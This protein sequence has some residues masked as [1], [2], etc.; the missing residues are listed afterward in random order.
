M[1]AEH[2]YYRS[3]WGGAQEEPGEPQE[4]RTS[5]CFFFFLFCCFFIFS[6]SG[7]FFYATLPATT[8]PQ[9]AHDSRPLPGFLSS[10]SCP[11]CFQWENNQNGAKRGR[12][13]T[14]LPHF[15]NHDVDEQQTAFQ[16]APHPAWAQIHAPALQL[17]GHPQGLPAHP[18]GES[19]AANTG[20]DWFK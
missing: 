2:L 1:Q 14:T 17:R 5:L 11:T 18:L 12:R 10:F 13:T 6:F 4:R 20:G 9:I 19:Q 15:C 7:F 16:H 3:D 8:G